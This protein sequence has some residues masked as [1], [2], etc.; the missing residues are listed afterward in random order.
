MI[1]RLGAGEI[2][3][4]LLSVIRDHLGFPGDGYCEFDGA[5]LVCVVSIP[6][7]SGDGLLNVE[8]SRI[9]IVVDRGADKVYIYHEDSPGSSPEI[10]AERFEKAG[11]HRE[12]F[13]EI[14]GYLVESYN[15]VLSDVQVSIDS[16]EDMVE[17]EDLRS[18]VRATYILRRSLIN[19]RRGLKNLVQM[20][21]EIH[22]DHEKLSMVKNQ[23]T[24]LELIDE[25]STGL[26][27]VEIYRE[28]LISL[29]EAHASL[30]GL[31]LNDIVKRL[32]AIT[33]VL[34]IPTLI[35]S[36]YGMN[37]DRSYP[38]NMPELSWSFGYI[39]ALTLMLASSIAGYLVLKIRGWF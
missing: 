11:D 20:L 5:W 12:A 25:A 4:S 16:V 7:V 32:T 2:D 30:L 9:V 38:L 29:R 39:Y 37:F 36:I 13:Q 28:T 26:E 27:T 35:A 1:R 22:S 15:M 33:L 34:M 8:L 23:H 31:R 19:V 24:L 17:S 21:R 3:P 18:V 6:R 10:P 14:L